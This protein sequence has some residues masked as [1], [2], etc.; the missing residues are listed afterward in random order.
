MG[1][2]CAWLCLAGQWLSENLCVL[3]M[4][5]L[6]GQFA[7]VTEEHW[8]PLADDSQGTPTK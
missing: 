1:W 7:F 3:N 2:G 6:V 8:N 4:L 5:L